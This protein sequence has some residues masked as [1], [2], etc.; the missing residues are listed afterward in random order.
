M[1]T[2]ESHRAAILGSKR[3][4]ISV[5]LDDMGYSI[6]MCAG[7]YSHGMMRTEA[8][9]NCPRCLKLTK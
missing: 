3:I 7:A 1:T 5:K 9:A 8:P 2:T 4:H 6:P